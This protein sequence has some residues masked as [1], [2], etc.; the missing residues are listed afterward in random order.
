MTR[1]SKTAQTVHK[2]RGQQDHNHKEHI[3]VGGGG[4]FEIVAM[5]DTYKYFKYAT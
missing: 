2:L 3:L 4:V 1:E 5:F